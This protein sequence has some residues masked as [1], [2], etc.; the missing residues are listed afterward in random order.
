LPTLDALKVW[1]EYQIAQGKGR[2]H[3]NHVVVIEDE[4]K[5]RA[6]NPPDEEGKK[7]TRIVWE[8]NDPDVYA[9]FHAEKEKYMKAAGGNPVIGTEAMLV[10][11]KMHDFEAVRKFVQSI[12]AVRDRIA[13]EKAK[14]SGVPRAIIPKGPI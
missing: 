6:E 8:T 1:V 7:K 5:Q 9:L 10:A 13:D 3:T 2:C 12:A 11:L 4:N 14:A